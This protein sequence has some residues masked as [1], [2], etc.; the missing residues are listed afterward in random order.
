MVSR[1]GFARDRVLKSDHFGRV[2]Q[3]RLPDGRSVVRRD[4]RA[5]PIWT[6]FVARRLASREARALQAASDV[7]GTPDVIGRTRNEL[8]RSWIAGRPMQ[9]VRPTDPVFY[10]EARRL[11]QRLHRAL[12]THN[13]LHKEPNWLVTEEGDPAL[14]DFQLASTFRRR[15]RW[16]RLLALE[17]LR[18]LLKHK[19]KYCRD[20][21]TAREWAVLRKRSWPARWWR[22]TVKP[23]YVWFTRRVLGWA[24]R[25]G[26]H[27]RRP[28]D[29]G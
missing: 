2:E 17:D 10:A 21:L 15:T 24:D 5:A 27:D 20:A 13:D 11:L 9:E 23:V 1:F 29:P 3:G 28:P 12:V 18:H 4:L 26:G 22:R 16:F 6:R 25:E 8:V 7:A 14:V 19:K